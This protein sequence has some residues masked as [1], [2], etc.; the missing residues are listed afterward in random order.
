MLRTKKEIFGLAHL[1]EFVL[2]GRTFSQ[3]SIPNISTKSKWL[4][5]VYPV[6]N[7]YQVSLGLILED[8][9]GNFWFETNGQGV[10]GY[11][12]DSFTHHLSDI[13]KVYEDGMQHNIVLSIVED[14]QGNI[15]VFVVKSWWS[16]C[17]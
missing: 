8:S 5:S 13:G 14:L 15:W 6:V 4:D 2:H 9:K 12:G 16:E 7:P 17:L 3:F 11:D 1:T 10:I